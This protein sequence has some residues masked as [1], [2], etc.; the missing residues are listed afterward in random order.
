MARSWRRRMRRGVMWAV[1]AV[2]LSGSTLRIQG[3][4][5]PGAMPRVRSTNPTIASAIADAQSRSSTFRSL[6][7][8]IEATDGIVYVEEGECHHHLRACFPPIVTSTADVRVLHVLVDARQEDWEVMSDIAHELQHALEVL[9]DRNARTNDR[10][11]FLIHPA[12]TM[13]RD[14]VETDAAVKA[15]DAV[16]SEVAAFARNTSTKGQSR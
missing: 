16:R 9:V 7:R 13:T 6:V 14:V 11:F 3:A 4:D 15:G 2:L 12:A 1:V 10:V 8:A 5:G